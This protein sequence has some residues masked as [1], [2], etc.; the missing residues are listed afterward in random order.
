MNL[1]KTSKDKY[2]V[3]RQ[4]DGSI[5]YAR[6]WGESH[7]GASR[8]SGGSYNMDGADVPAQWRALDTKQHHKIVGRLKKEVKD[9]KRKVIPVEQAQNI[10]PDRFRNINPFKDECYY[11][12]FKTPPISIDGKWCGDCSQQ[13]YYGL[14]RASVITTLFLLVAWLIFVMTLIPYG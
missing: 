12:K 5:T 3:F 2:A 1:P 8:G 14:E 4:H 7:I 13:E 10:S 11:A 9:G 6:W